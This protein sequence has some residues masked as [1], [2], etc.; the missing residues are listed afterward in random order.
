MDLGPKSFMYGRKG[1]WPQPSPAHPQGEAFAVIHLPFIEKLDWWIH[2]GSRYMYSLGMAPFMLLK[3]LFFNGLSPVSD[4]EFHAILTN[5]MM[6]K[7]L[8]PKLDEDDLINFK[9]VLEEGERYMIT[10]LQAVQTVK[11]YKGIHVS[12]TKTLFKMKMN[13]ANEMEYEVVAIYVFKTN[14]LFRPTD[15]DAWE[16]AK[17]FVLQGGAICATLVVHPNLH[18]PLDAINAITKTSLPKKHP[19]VQLLK[20]HMR[21]TL[22][23]ENAVLTFGLSVLKNKPWMSYAPYPGHYDGLR[24]LLVEGFTGIKGNDS[25][26]PYEFPMNPPKIYSKYGD[27]QQA[28]F[29]VMYTFVSKVLEKVDPNDRYVISWANYISEH[30]PGFPSGSEIFEGDNLVR[31]VTSYF[32]SITVAH[33]IDHYNYGE[34][35]VRKVPMR[36]RQAPPVKGVKMNPLSK[37]VTPIDQMKYLMCMKMF[38]GPTNVTTLYKSKYKF[39]VEH[40]LESAVQEFKKEMEDLEKLM[41]EKGMNYIPLK[42]IAASIQY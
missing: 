26:P 28:Y 18:F 34:M 31:A 32:W 33:S 2:I 29:D 17:Y 19:I 35:D 42:E 41:I 23:L 24:D 5:S 15:G 14:E 37:L 9:D 6:S 36:L 30:V 40:G 8:C 7:F 11:P 38:F 39:E 4:T 27:F 20:P 22:P 1:P 10:D 12:A 21:F 13:D 3:A 25:Y 16:L